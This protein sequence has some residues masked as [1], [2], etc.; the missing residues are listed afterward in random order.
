M[1]A[2][3]AQWIKRRTGR[4]KWFNVLKGT[5]DNTFLIKNCVDR[6]VRIIYPVLQEYLRVFVVTLL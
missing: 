1:A 5:R 3:G 6:Y 2:K 4:V